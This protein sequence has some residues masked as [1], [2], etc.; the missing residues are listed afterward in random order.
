MRS[1]SSC[2]QGLGQFA[3]DDVAREDVAVAID[4]RADAPGFAVATQAAAADLQRAHW[5]AHA[6]SRASVSASLTESGEDGFDGGV[7]TD[8][9][10]ACAT[11]SS[12]W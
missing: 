3:A 6:P 12:A 5:G 1:P 8:T 10:G 11:H 4:Y 7:E 2:A 9:R